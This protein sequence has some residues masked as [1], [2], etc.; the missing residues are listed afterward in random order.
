MYYRM[1]GPVATLKKLG[2]K[3]TALTSRT[4]AHYKRHGLAV[5][6]GKISAR[7]KS[8]LAAPVGSDPVAGLAASCVPFRSEELCPV[9]PIDASTTL[10]QEIRTDFDSIE[11]IELLLATYGRR[12]KNVNEALLLDDCGRVLHREKFSSRVVADN[13]FQ[14]VLRPRGLKAPAS[15]RLYL[16]LRSRNGTARNA[17]AAWRTAGVSGGLMLGERL[18]DQSLPACIGNGERKDR[19]RELPGQLVLRVLGRHR[20]TEPRYRQP[21]LPSRFDEQ[22]AHS[23]PRSVI[24]RNTGG[25][26]EPLEGGIALLVDL[27][28][29]ASLLERGLVDVLYL[30]DIRFDDQVRDL[31]KSAHETH[32]PT[33]YVAAAD[34]GFERRHVQ[35]G[36]GPRLDSG[37]SALDDE[38]FLQ[39]QTLRASEVVVC[40]AAS[41]A[42]LARRQ[43]KRVLE[44]GGPFP[45][46]TDDLAALSRDIL[47]R[48]KRL[49]R[50]VV[51]IVTILYNKARELPATLISY[52]RQTYA[53]EIE[54]V[55]VDDASPDNSVE[56]VER[57]AADRCNGGSLAVRIVRNGRNLGNCRSRNVGIAAARGD[58][59][60][61]ID[62]DCLLN[63]DF[64]RGHVEAHAFDDCEVAI[65]PH[66]IET[67]G[68]SPAEVLERYELTPGL[69]LAHSE[70]QDPV[71]KSSLLNCITRNFSIKREAIVEDLF[72]P[73]FSY[74]A[75]PSSGFG[76]EDVEMGYRLYKR[77][78]RVKFVE[79]AFSVHLS[80]A[81]D[82]SQGNKP[83]RSMRNFRRLFEIHPELALV[84]RRWSRETFARI[85]NWA[86]HA[87]LDV[88][89]DRVWLG[90]V[91]GE[92][93][94][95]PL[96]KTQPR[97]LRVLTYRWHVP[98]QYELYKLPFDVTLLT[99]LGSPMTESWE[100]G[101]RPMPANARFADF[102]KVEPREFD[103]AILHFD[104]NVLTPE[105]TNGVIGPDW[106]AAFRWFREQLPLPKWRSVT[107]RPSSMGNTTST[108]AD[109]TSCSPIEAGRRRWSTFSATYRSFAIRTRPCA[110]GNSA[111]RGSFGTVWIRP[112]FRRPPTREGLSR[113][114]VR[115]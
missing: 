4:R 93:G 59:L 13:A 6:L 36:A 51:S 94:T 95:G 25:E 7:A 5:T 23:A 55:F 67:Q 63:R 106:G 41:A 29:A 42:D 96:L 53:G 31:L 35:L 109:R 101:Q 8:V 77:G 111:T 11:S 74:S 114:S 52:E 57:W 46:T 68:D 22:V 80:S 32:V 44:V 2:T 48:H 10:V 78:A 110:N 12:N 24:V 49:H 79:E 33:A 69:A 40:L 64:V 103:L 37:W 21:A 85:S 98:H 86:D 84:A 89:G 26:L 15:G 66:N 76:W 71:N 14:P 39:L 83:V 20:S 105:N 82:P 16:A 60:V 91:L 45:G 27:A 62:A 34:E 28:D 102:R 1:F 104:E 81:A 50:P 47:R 58:L 108:T 113:R 65:G 112:N 100:F 3:A 54:L 38:A 115:S 17:I 30:P 43:R 107:A 19:L 97:R 18:D 61:V 92:A 70:L 99:G 72:D 75:D 90:N 9:G 88:Q 56:V 73:A 87:R